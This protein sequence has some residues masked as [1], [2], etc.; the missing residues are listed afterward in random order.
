MS[1]VSEREFPDYRKYIVQP[2]DLNQLEKQIKDNVYGSPQ[3]FEA[4]AKWILHNSIIY[5]GC[6]HKLLIFSSVFKILFC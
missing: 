2:M 5:N 3:A 1:A 4:D 6:K